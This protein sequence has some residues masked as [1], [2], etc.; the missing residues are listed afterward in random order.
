[1]KILYLSYH[2]PPSNT[3]ST[4]VM[5]YQ[6]VKQ[7]SEDNSL[8]VIT[9]KHEKFQGNNELLDNLNENVNV[10]FTEPGFLHRKFYDS[11][12]GI[13]IKNNNHGLKRI[14]K[15]ISKFKELILIPDPVID[16][17]FIAFKKSKKVIS[18]SE[19][20]MI[21]SSATPYTSHIIGFFLSKVFKKPLILFYGDPWVY[22]QS[23]KRGKI[24]FLFE[25]FIEQKII[26]RSTH[27]FFV[28][29]TTKELYLEKY[30][31]SEESVSVV[32]LGYDKNDFSKKKTIDNI[33][34]IRLLYGG[35]LN[36]IHR[37]P[38]PFFR[39][40]SSLSD[41]H[42]N[43]IIFDLF[44][45]EYDKYNNLVK[46]YKIDNVVK[47]KKIIA[48]KEFLKE[49]QNAN[50]LVLFG[51]SSKLQIP[52]KVFD[53]IGSRTRILLINNNDDNLNDP[54][55]KILTEFESNYSVLNREIDIKET[56]EHC[57]VNYDLKENHKNDETKVLKY[58]W[59]NT[60]K[61]L[62]NYITSFKE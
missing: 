18:N 8:E 53:F 39:A 30:K 25:K 35:S 36:P 27:V 10:N 48:Y 11:P 32:T 41:N 13:N 1:M 24:R 43:R 17:F 22:E 38:L 42:K 29:N 23:R 59:K 52:G 34:K 7:L 33:G 50:L 12:N 57:I 62:T 55:H 14:F 56:I 58:Q 9:M 61:P 60:L 45:D 15:K 49:A 20:D 16:W 46:V 44:T 28:T 2:F 51:N 47:V 54:T 40:I 5:N 19:I 37:D 21:F 4:S 6:I 3:S 31:I 26:N